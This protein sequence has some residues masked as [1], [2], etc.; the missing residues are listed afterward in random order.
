MP[1]SL[2][3][4]IEGAAIRRIAAMSCA[5]AAWLA[6]AGCASTRIDSTWVNPAAAGKPIEGPVL[7][8]GVARDDVVR[9]IFEDDMTT[10]LAARGVRAIRSYESLRE[11][12]DAGAPERLLAA[13]RAAGARQ[14]LSTAVIGQER[15][16]VVTQEP[17]VMVGMGGYRGWYGAHWGMSVPLRTEVRTYAVYVAQTSL[18]TVATDQIEW[19]ARSRTDAP[20]DIERETRAFVDVVVEAM[21]RAGLLGAAK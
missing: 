10:K 15:Q 2:S 6:L 7:V 3:S 5:A 19:V 20:T 21:S 13:A 1:I 9:R 14:V 12:L 8:V 17:R 18:V 4:C 11:P 16:Q